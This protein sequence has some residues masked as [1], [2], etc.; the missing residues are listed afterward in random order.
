MELALVVMSVGST[1]Q[2]EIQQADNDNKF[3]S[4]TYSL[5]CMHG[6]HCHI[7]YKSI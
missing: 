5:Q 3:F 1:E 2:G 7:T 6:F 4:V